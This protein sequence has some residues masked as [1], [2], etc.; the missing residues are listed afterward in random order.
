M[1]QNSNLIYVYFK[2]FCYL[3][4]NMMMNTANLL[5]TSCMPYP[6]LSALHGLSLVVSQ[7]LLGEELIIKSKMNPY[8]Y[9]PLRKKKVLLLKLCCD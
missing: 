3:F 7:R 1:H 5:N 6:V 4:R 8:F 2:I 9:I